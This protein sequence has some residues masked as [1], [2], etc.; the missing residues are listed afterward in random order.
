MNER[1]NERTN[2]QRDIIRKEKENAIRRETG[3]FHHI[4]TVFP[5]RDRP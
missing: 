1:K 5:E 2:E 3:G 4:F